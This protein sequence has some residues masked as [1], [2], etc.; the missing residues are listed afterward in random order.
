MCCGKEGNKKAD[1][2]LKTAI[3]SNCGK[4]GHLRAVCENT[5][6]HEIEKDNDEPSPEVTVEAVWCVAVQNIVEDD[7]CDHSEKHERSSEHRD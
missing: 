4:V 3:C 2:K 7:H 6:T 1:C 5:N